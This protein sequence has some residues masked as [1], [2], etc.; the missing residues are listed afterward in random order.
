MLFFPLCKKQNKNKNISANINNQTNT[1]SLLIHFLLKNPVWNKKKESLQLN[2]VNVASTTAHLT[3]RIIRVIRETRKKK[4]HTHIV[5]SV[6]CKDVSS[7]SAAVQRGVLGVLC[8]ERVG[9]HTYYT[10]CY[11]C[12]HEVEGRNPFA[13]IFSPALHLLLVAYLLCR[14]ASIV[15]S[16][17]LEES[18]FT[19]YV[20]F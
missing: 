15:S 9:I 1:F 20:A 8:T 16:R 6:K 10:S 7:A 3:A 2:V 17:L 14:T 12:V 11:Q 13:T 5:I 4:T 18:L 19:Q